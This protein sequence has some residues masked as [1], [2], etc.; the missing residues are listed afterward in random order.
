MTVHPATD[1]ALS[2]RFHGVRGSIAAPGPGTLRYGGNTPCIE[3]RAAG[4][5]LVFDAGTGIRSLGDTIV[6]DWQAAGA[7]A[8]RSVDLFLTHY[9]WDHI[10]GLPFFAPLFDPTATLRLHGPAPE[11]PGAE[12]TAC[13]RA[14]GNPAVA[15]AALGGQFAGAHFPVGPEAV[16]AAVEACVMDQPWRSGASEVAA[17]RVAHPGVTLAYRVRV[18]DGGPSVVYAPDCELAAMGRTAPTPSWYDE[19][20]E[21]AAGADV[22]IH[23][24]MYDDGEDAARRGWG[25]STPG[26]AARLATAAGVRRLRLF[27]HAPWR[28][29]AAVAALAAAAAARAPG[30]DV[31]AAAEGEVL[32]IP[33]PGRTEE[34]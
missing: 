23:D 29:D 3:V 34:S 16:A 20:V 11:L 17:L 33:D 30:L 14:T 8:Q 9:H 1:P 6:R 25:H 27:H 31:A 18:G 12:R 4:A 21:F 15:A 2:I 13:G 7:G 32:I 26:Q 5:L 19:L 28:D 24:A 22:L 10:Q